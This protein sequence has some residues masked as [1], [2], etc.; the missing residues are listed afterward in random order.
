MK[1][2]IDGEIHFRLGSG[3][4]SQRWGASPVREL[5]QIKSLIL[6]FTELSVTNPDLVLLCWPT[7]KIQCTA[8][9]EAS[10]PALES[11]NT[12]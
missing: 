7:I 3:S 9:G 5:G 2:E 8:T 10:I 4:Q 11:Q 1:A 6:L 12:P